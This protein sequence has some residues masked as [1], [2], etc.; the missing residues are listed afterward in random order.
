MLGAN[1]SCLIML[2]LYFCFSLYRLLFSL[3]HSAPTKPKWRNENATTKLLYASGVNWIFY[4]DC[5]RFEPC[6]FQFQKVLR[7]DDRTFSC[8]NP[9]R[10][11]WFGFCCCCVQLHFSC[12]CCYCCYQALNSLK[13]VKLD[14]ELLSKYTFNVRLKYI[15]YTGEE[16]KLPEPSYVTVWN[17][18]RQR[19]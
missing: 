17:C 7:Q 3:H 4:L 5:K 6:N 10:Q 13:F 9:F 16:K 8:M 11:T 19:C 1:F 2:T 18:H 12:C 14:T 15:V